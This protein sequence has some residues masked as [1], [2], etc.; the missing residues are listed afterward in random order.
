MVKPI[1]KI[2][3]Y[4]ICL[5]LIELNKITRDEAI[6]WLAKADLTTEDFDTWYDENGRKFHFPLEF[7]KI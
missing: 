7:P 1:N 6:Q 2:A 4:T 5:E 3:L